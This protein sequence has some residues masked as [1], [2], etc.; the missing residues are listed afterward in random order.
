MLI[1][2]LFI[3]WQS[4]LIIP[5]W[6]Y[7]KVG[8]E[9]LA[10]AC[11]LLGVIATVYSCVYNLGSGNSEVLPDPSLLLFSQLLV[12]FAHNCSDQLSSA[13]TVWLFTPRR[14][15]L[16]TALLTLRFCRVFH[17]PYWA[18]KVW[19]LKCISNTYQIWVELN[20]LC[21]LSS[22][23]GMAW[24]YLDFLRLSGDFAI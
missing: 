21:M 3:F 7:C 23:V 19:L 1:A 10:F 24:S 6:S 14:Y 11:T 2:V 16:V 9:F 17:C 13:Q 22:K 18:C 15:I 8:T 20:L 5:T 12:F 4:L